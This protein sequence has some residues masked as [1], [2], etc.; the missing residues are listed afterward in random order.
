MAANT[1]YQ[2]APTRDSFEDQHSRPYTQAPPSYQDAAPD[3]DAALAAGVPRSSDD[4]VPDDFK[5]GETVAEAT[6]DIRMAFV[7]KVYA[8][9]TLQVLATAGLC[10]IPALSHDYRTWMLEHS[11]VVLVSALGAMVAMG[12]TFWKRRSYPANL[13]FL[14]LFTGLEAFAVSA[15]TSL[16]NPRIVLAAL[17]FTLGT[18]VAL[19]LFACQTRYDFTA[20]QPYLFGAL[21]VMVLFGTFLLLRM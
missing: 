10:L 12:L 1:R 14:S 3:T 6:L 8:I 7:R 13:L 18:F 11:W 17:A 4:N 21:W 5:F 9:L 2:P 16:Y 20:W 15:V 19:T